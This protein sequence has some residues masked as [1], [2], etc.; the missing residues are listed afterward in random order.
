MSSPAKT[1]TVSPRK[2]ASPGLSVRVGR[3]R[4]ASLVKVEKLNDESQADVLDQG[5]YENLNAEWVNRKG[6]FR[7]FNVARCNY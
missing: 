6:A 3:E 5:V 4:S 7:Y 1:S 2:S